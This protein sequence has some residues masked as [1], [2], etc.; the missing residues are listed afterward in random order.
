MQDPC[1]DRGLCRDAENDY[2]CACQP[3]YTGKNCET[4]I[5]ECAA[6]PC[7]NGG[8]CQDLVRCSEPQCTALHRY[9]RWA[10]TPATALAPA[11]AAGTARSMLTS[12]TIT[13]A[14][15]SAG[16]VS[17]CTTTTSVA[18]TP[19]SPAATARSTSTNASPGLVSITQPVS[20]E[21]TTSHA[22]ACVAIL[23]RSVHMFIDAKI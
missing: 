16:P 18:A 17:T 9:C 2:T 15:R 22:A 1:G 8:N 14:G 3:G 13:R 19:A 7:Q 10:G 5:D 20:T 11:T 4:N 21:L 23:A 6:A 12:A